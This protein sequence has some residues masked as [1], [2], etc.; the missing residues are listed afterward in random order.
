MAGSRVALLVATDVYADR[1]LRRLRAPR[2]DATALASVLGDRDIGGFG[3]ETLVNWPSHKISIRANE[4]FS[5]A[6]R[7]DL[8][9]FYISG[10]GLKDRTGRLRFVTTNTQLD[11]LASTAIQS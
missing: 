2:H 11:L 7:N 9:L 10:H 4:L 5:K 1:G 6:G 8:V 3:V